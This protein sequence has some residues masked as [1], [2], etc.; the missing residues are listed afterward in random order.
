MILY[1]SRS[2]ANADKAKARPV[3]PVKI[4]THVAVVAGRCAARSSITV[5]SL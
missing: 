4:S 5:A 3:M 1:P 2:Q